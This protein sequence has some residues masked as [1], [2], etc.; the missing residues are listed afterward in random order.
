MADPV[1]TISGTVA[2][3]ALIFGTLLKYKVWPFNGNPSNGNGRKA[4]KE[5]VEAIHVPIDVKLAEHSQA[6]QELNIVQVKQNM[7]LEN[8]EKQLGEGKERFEK[9]QTDIAGINTSLA[10]LAERAKKPRATDG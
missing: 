6:F 3:A 4:V 7:I 10:V 2:G 1:Y 8:H 9:V 5:H